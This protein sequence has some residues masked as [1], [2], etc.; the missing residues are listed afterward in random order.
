MK[1]LFTKSEIKSAARKRKNSKSTGK[2]RNSAKLLKSTSTTTI[3]NNIAETG[4][5]LNKIT[6]NVLIPLGN[7]KVCYPLSRKSFCHQFK[8][9]LSNVMCNISEILL[10][11]AAYQK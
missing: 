3:Y 7:L 8:K 1:I 4:K 10:T 6:Q 5:H 9:G 11:Q 2:D